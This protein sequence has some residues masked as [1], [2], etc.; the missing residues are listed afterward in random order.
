MV[1]THPYNMW[2]LHIKFFTSMSKKAWDEAAVSQPFP[3]GMTFTEEYEGVDGKS[4]LPGSGRVG[5]ID[6]TDGKK[7]HLAAGLALA[8]DCVG[9]FCVQHMHK[10]SL[11][12]TILRGPK[13]TI[14]SKPV[15]NYRS[16]RHIHLCPMS[17]S[18]RVDRNL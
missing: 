10:S 18:H 13:C 6:V 15:E 8:E 14:C 5:P 7:V 4:G 16:V 9:Q 11:I 3:A 2:P 12:R 17:H 1:T